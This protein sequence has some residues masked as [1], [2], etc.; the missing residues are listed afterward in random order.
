M[1]IQEE[2]RKDYRLAT[3]VYLISW[4]GI[5]VIMANGLSEMKSELILCIGICILSNIF[6]VFFITCPNCDKSISKAAYKSKGFSLTPDF[7]FRT[8]G[9]Q[10]R[11][12]GI[13]FLQDADTFDGKNT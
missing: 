1:T 8:V 12:C 4:L 7:T 6:T 9:D 11:E 2:L 10:C 5:A 13:D 3:I